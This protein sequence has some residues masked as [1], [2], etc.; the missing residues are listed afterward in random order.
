MSETTAPRVLPRGPLLLLAAMLLVA[1][2]G[3][4]V[5]RIT[6]AQIHKPDAAAAVVRELRF[7]DLADGSVAVID[8]R[9]GQLIEKMTGEQGFLRGTLRGLARERKRRG[10]GS[11]RPFELIARADGRLTLRDPATEARID[12]ESFGPTNASVF[13]RWVKNVPTAGR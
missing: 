1:T 12:L 3:T 9:N 6:G 8:G 2:V 10:I 5:V 13:V 4:A 7:E 11:E